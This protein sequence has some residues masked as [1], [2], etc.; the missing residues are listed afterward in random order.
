MGCAGNSIVQTPNLDKLA[1]SGVRFTHAFSS[2]P[3][4][5]PAR[6]TL[7]TGQYSW[8]N[9]VSFFNNPIA[10]SAP[11]WPKVLLDVGYENFYTGKWHN[12][13]GPQDRGFSSGAKIFQGGMGN[14][15]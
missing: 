9:K 8:T 10:K 14:H 13:G 3:I 12:E 6:A 7:I 15:N 1:G 2:N 11:A 4:C 5:T